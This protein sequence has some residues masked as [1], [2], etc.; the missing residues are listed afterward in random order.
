MNI[1]TGSIGRAKIVLAYEDDEHPTSVLAVLSAEIDR[2]AEEEISFQGP[3]EFSPEAQDHIRGIVFPIVKRIVNALNVEWSPIILSVSNIGAASVQNK[4]LLVDGFSADLAVFLVLLSTYLNIPLRQDFAAT[5]HIC[6]RQGD[7]AIVE[8]IPAKIRG[9][10][11]YD[12][13]TT[14]VCP[15]PDGDPSTR[16]ITPQ[17]QEELKIAIA[18]SKSAIKFVLVNALRDVIGRIIDEGQLIYGSLT[19]GFFHCRT[20]EFMNS[21]PCSEFITGLTQQLEDRFWKQVS[22]FLFAGQAGLARRFISLRIQSHTSSGFY[23]K[24]FG[25]NLFNTFQSL[26]PSK[27]PRKIIDHFLQ[28]R[29]LKALAALVEDTDLADFKYLTESL[30]QFD[31]VPANSILQNPKTDEEY[32]ELLKFLLN[33]LNDTNLVNSFIG[34][35][36]EARLSF[37][38]IKNRTS[39]YEEFFETTESCH[40]CLNRSIGIFQTPGH[41]SSAGPEA[42]SLLKRS[43]RSDNAIEIAWRM[44]K[45]GVDG[46]LRTIVDEMTKQFILEKKNEHIEH[47]LTE[48]LD[49]DHWPDLVKFSA[50][51]KR[52]LGQLLPVEF[53]ELPANHIALNYKEFTRVIIESINS[54]NRNLQSYR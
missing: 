5:G 25:L 29:E 47:I 27:R 24:D 52:Q 41:H 54:L 32:D 20:D 3:G 8:A 37:R 18:S 33:E 22:G 4:I 30:S 51:V 14:F 38:L 50:A 11:E 39:S 1:E 10:Q 13:I 15:D 7:L 28:G 17:K 43:F 6:S 40:T 12:E 2:T 19:A 21:N 49:P 23:P 36:D 9:A 42:L 46:G 48:I 16:I 35:I 44:A 31:S 45:T 26:P 34:A 53:Q